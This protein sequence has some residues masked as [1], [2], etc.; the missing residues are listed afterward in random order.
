MSDRFENTTKRLSP[1]IPERSNTG[2]PALGP[3]LLVSI[4]MRTLVSQ[5]GNSAPSA[6]VM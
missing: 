3:R 5:N 4:L 6:V 1:T 2:S